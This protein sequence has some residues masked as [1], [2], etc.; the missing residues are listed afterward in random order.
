ML[1]PIC[2]ISQDKEG[3]PLPSKTMV[4][5]SKGAPVVVTGDIAGDVAVYRLHDYEDNNPVVQRDRL[6]KLLYPAGYNK[7]NL[8]EEA[9]T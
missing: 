2:I 8:T 9:N 7:G 3:N 6:V 1:D 5:F 4:R